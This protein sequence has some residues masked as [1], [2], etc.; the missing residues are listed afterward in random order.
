MKTMQDAFEHTLADIYY[1]EGALVKAL[2]K[3]AKA[4]GNADLKA[5]FTGHLEETK[6][7]IEVLKQVFQ[8]IGLKP[9]G[10]KCDA[11]EGLIKEASGLMEEATGEALDT[12]LLAAGQAV[13]HYEIARYTSLSNWAV[14]L[15]HTT[16]QGL[17][18]GILDQE[19][20]A[21]KKLATIN[22]MMETGE[23]VDKKAKSGKAAK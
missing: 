4:V 18:Q 5:A 19:V 22:T 2:P 3:M 12:M 10:E 7:Q 11:I 6:H 21:D 16:A 8:S 23:F 17:L 15:G 20:A 13:E 9:K 14:M 1:A